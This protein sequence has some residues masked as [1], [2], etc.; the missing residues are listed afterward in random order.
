M[1]FHS[2]LARTA[3][4]FVCLSAASLIAPSVFAERALP[5]VERLKSSPVLQHL[6][7]NPFSAPPSTAPEQTVAQMYLPDGFR[8][9]LIVA[10]P[11]L[12]QPVAFAIDE[13]GRIWVAEAYSYPQK[14]PEGKG[15]DKEPLRRRLAGLEL[16]VNAC[17]RTPMPASWKSTSAKLYENR[18]PRVQRQAERLAAVFGDD[19]MFP[20][21]RSILADP[22][23]AAATRQH[24]FN[25][26]SKAPDRGALPVFLGLLDDAKFRAPAINLL[27]RFDSAQI[28]TALLTRY[29]TFSAPERMAALNTLMSRA[30]FALPLLDAVAG[31][32]L[33]REQL[34]AFHV[35][36]LTE[37]K[38][39]E[40]DKRVTT[41]WGRIQQTPAEK[42]SLMES[43]EKNFSE[44]P[45]WA[46]ESS[47]G[48]QHFQKLCSQCHRLGNDGV[49]L[50][51]ELTGAGKHGIRY[52]LENTIDPNTVIGTDFQMTTVETRGGDVLS[53]L[54]VNE[55]PGAV[56]IRTTVGETVVTKADIATRETSENS[57]MPEGLLE[58]LS[59][60]EQI[61]LLKFLTSN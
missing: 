38:N 40:V 58:S 6:K 13:R 14:Q 44:A 36:Q 24:A 25:M 56:T 28:P 20:R 50:G 5:E 32:Q 10:E 61:E 29:E 43:L 30:T 54:I 60:R 45:L 46:Y 16:A 15:L 27:A 51:P 49:R 22:K 42:Q 31:G 2:S 35:R 19:S 37:L 21:L 53:G 1:N 41:T 12:H 18:D 7:P 55:T 47:A 57:L 4:S 39:T 9:E 59:A 3:L 34:T 17:G 33:K 52:Y 26:L 11:D 23:A 48:R 8:A